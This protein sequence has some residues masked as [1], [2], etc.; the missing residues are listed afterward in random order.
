MCGY[1]EV[2]APG[3]GA[4]PTAWS[5]RSHDRKQWEKFKALPNVLY[6]DGNEWGLY[7]SGQRVGDLVRL[8]GHVRT[9]GARLAPQG[10]DFAR[11]LSVF[12]R[13]SP[14][15]PRT[16]GQLVNSVAGLCR[17]LRDEVADALISERTAGGGPFTNL[18]SDW[19]ELL[20]PDASDA[21]FADGYAQTVTFGLLLARVEGIDLTGRSM[22]DIARLLGQEHSLMGRAVAVLTE[23]IVGGMALTLDTLLRVIGVVDWTRFEDPERDPYLHLYEHFLEVYDPELR[24]QTGSY[25]T[26]VAV[27]D[28]MTRLAEELLRHKLGLPLG[29]AA[30]PVVVVDPG[31]GTGTYLL[32]IIE[33]AAETIA[34]EEGEGAVPARLRQMAR[35]IIGFEKQTGPRSAAA[36]HRAAPQGR[37]TDSRLRGQDARRDRL[38]RGYTDAVRR[39]RAN[40]TGP[41]SGVDLPGVRDAGRPALVRLPEAQPSRATRQPTRRH[42]GH[43]LDAR[44]DYGVAEPAQ[45]ARPP[46]RATTPPGGPAHRDP[47]QPIC[48]CHRPRPGGR[49]AGARTVPQARSADV[50]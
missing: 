25:Y 22:G 36:A 6:T 12:L 47:R 24:K 30:E 32:N 19:R 15:P 31:M 17:L 18:A 49:T 45:R 46:R 35:R 5:A 33:R 20:F 48:H 9:S 28:A 39:R 8:T 37:A 4:D 7:R 1:V 21:E 43:K 13:W 14:T 50:R 29:F 11:L 34:D 40:S 23:D 44:D 10:S 2:K 26:P 16:L 3:K 42:Q 27:V 38:R 41:P